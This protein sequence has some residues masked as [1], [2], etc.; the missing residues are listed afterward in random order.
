MNCLRRRSVSFTLPSSPPP[1]HHMALRRRALIAQS[2]T[3]A[4]RRGSLGRVTAQQVSSG[5]DGV[6]RLLRRAGLSR[7]P[8]CLGPG[9]LEPGSDFLQLLTA[10]AGPHLREPLVL[11]D[12]MVTFSI[13][14]VVLASKRSAPGA[15]P[16]SSVHRTS[17]TWC[18]SYDSSMSSSGAGSR[19]V[20][21]S[22]CITL[23]SRCRCA[24]SA[25]R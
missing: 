25:A 7:R 11:F 15:S 16:A 10:E 2:C 21:T 5:E 12:V 13:S 8:G 14:T 20:R 1:H 6:Y 9:F 19:V 23:R 24:R 4:T 17:A 18:S 3:C 22:G